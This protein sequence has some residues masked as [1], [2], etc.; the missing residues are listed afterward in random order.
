MSDDYEH[1]LEVLLVAMDEIEGI[2]SGIAP[3]ER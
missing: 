3:E 1:T 2:D